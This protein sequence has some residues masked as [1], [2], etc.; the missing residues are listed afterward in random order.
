MLAY[1]RRAG[2]ATLALVASLP[3]PL[4]AALVDDGMRLRALERELNRAIT[5]R[6]TRRVGELLADDW[7]SVSGIGKVRTKA[8]VL[9]E[10]A[11]TEIEFQ[12]LDTRDVLVRIWGDTA[13]ITGTVRQRFRQRGAQ[14]ELTLRYTDTWTR[15]GDAWRQVSGHAS[16]LPD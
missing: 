15:F 12:E 16:R 1:A 13:V 8:D 11:L 9:S 7:I 5:Q 2:L 10:L 4:Y 14:H 6:D 3:S